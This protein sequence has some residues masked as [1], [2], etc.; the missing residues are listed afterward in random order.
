MRAKWVRGMQQWHGMAWSTMFYIHENHQNE[1]PDGYSQGLPSIARW[2]QARPAMTSASEQ[3]NLG[4]W[5]PQW[6]EWSSAFQVW[7]GHYGSKPWKPGFQ[8]KIVCAHWCSSPQYGICGISMYI[9]ASSCLTHP[10]N[11]TSLSDTGPERGRFGLMIRSGPVSRNWVSNWLSSIAGWL[12]R[13]PSNFL[14][15]N[16]SLM[17][18]NM[19][20]PTLDPILVQFVRKLQQEID[21]SSSNLLHPQLLTPHNTIPMAQSEHLKSEANMGNRCHIGL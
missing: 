9:M 6:S 2:V 15:R 1:L 20:S 21:N 5:M 13:P 19:N 4:S 3:L 17:G 7:E 14:R 8:T 18:G 16:N 11:S 10:Y 12:K